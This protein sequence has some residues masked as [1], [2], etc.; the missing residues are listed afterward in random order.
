ML[1]RLAS[2]HGELKSD[3]SRKKISP[4]APSHLCTHPH[5]AA[6]VMSFFGYTYNKW[7]FPG[8]VDLSRTDFWVAAASM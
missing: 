3:A 2:K 5:N 8:I 1:Y 7:L 6:A 4:S